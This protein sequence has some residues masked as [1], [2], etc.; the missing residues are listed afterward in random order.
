MAYQLLVAWYGT[1]AGTGGT[2]MKSIRLFSNALVALAASIGVGSAI[3]DTYCPS[4]N[5]GLG[6]PTSGRYV[7]VQG[8]ST[9][10]CQFQNGNFIGDNFSAYFP[11]Y[12]LID[13]DITAGGVDP[14]NG[15]SLTGSTSGTWSVNSALWST[16]TNL[17][18]AFHFGNGGGSPDSFIVQLTPTNTT[19]LWSFNAIA[20]EFVNGLSNAYLIGTG[21]GNNVPEPASLALVALSLIGWAA[22]RRRA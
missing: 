20:P 8:A 4:P 3:A 21:P 17:F 18:L 2:Y 10:Y 9:G 22:V 1:H 13:K 15:F 11:S 16:H 19:G 5:G 7:F 6:P 12:T 14:D